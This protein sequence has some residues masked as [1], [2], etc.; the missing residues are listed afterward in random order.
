MRS[1]TTA[2]TQP[3]LKAYQAGVMGYRYKGVRCLK[4]PVDIAIYMRLLW[5]LRP[6][7]IIEIGSHSGGG[8]LLL[9]DLGRMLGLDAAVVSIDLKRPDGVDDP[10]IKFLEGDVMALD[11]VLE[12]AAA[13]DGLP[14][15]WFVTE[16]SAHSYQGCMAA[17]D[18]FARLME[19]GDVLAM[20]D[21]VLADLGLSEKYDG[22]PNR[23]IAEFFVARP[24]VFELAEDL[25]DMFGPNATYNPNG[26][27]RRL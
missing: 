22:G 25:C 23:A 21:G 7:T 6:R 18:V 13:A 1:F 26:Y 17:L 20:E 11:P 16:D 9:A 12:E 5:D 14:H 27:L 24:D 4:S 8:A 19:K 10:R 2:F 15:P 3:M